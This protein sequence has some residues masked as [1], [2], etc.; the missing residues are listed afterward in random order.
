[1]RFPQCLTKISLVIAL[2]SISALS[3]ADWD[4]KKVYVR[5]VDMFYLSTTIVRV[6]YEVVPG[7]SEAPEI[8]CGPNDTQIPELTNHY[9]ASYWNNTNAFHQLLVAQLLAAQAQ[10][11]PVDLF[12]VASGCNV[13]PSY[14]YGGL[15]RALNGVSVSS[16]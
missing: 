11:I 14:G 4:V 6:V 7:F 5:K 10:D 8:G 3:F 9:Q 12:F 1:M 13:T 15:G 16:D 2:F